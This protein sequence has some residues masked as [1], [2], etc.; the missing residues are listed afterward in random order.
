VRFFTHNEDMRTSDIIPDIAQRAKAASIPYRQLCKK[1][2]INIATFNRWRT[3]EVSPT[4]RS[5]DAMQDA[6]DELLK[7]Q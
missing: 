6:L 1:A 3:G 2:E 4:A 5:I 7:A